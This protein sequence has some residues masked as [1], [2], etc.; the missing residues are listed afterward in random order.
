VS[1]TV[2]RRSV[3]MVDPAALIYDYTIV[4]DTANP[5]TFEAWTP[6]LEAEGEIATKQ[7]WDDAWAEIRAG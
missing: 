1:G 7:D 5:I 3:D 6:P 2:N 4:E